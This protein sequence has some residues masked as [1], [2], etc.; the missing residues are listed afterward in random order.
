MPHSAR[1]DRYSRHLTPRAEVIL[2]PQIQ[3]QYPFRLAH[4][5]RIQTP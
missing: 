2:A 1:K 3:R 5:E 4:I